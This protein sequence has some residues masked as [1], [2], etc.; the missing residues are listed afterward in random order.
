MSNK[1]IARRTAIKV[2]FGGVDISK[3]IDKYLLSLTYTDNEEDETD[4]LQIKLQDR[5]GIWLEKWLNKAI[6]GALE[7]NTNA[8]SSSGTTYTVT[9]KIGLPK[10]IEGM[11]S[12]CSAAL[13]TIRLANC[14][15]VV[16][17][18]SN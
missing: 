16:S 3:S 14:S 2:V 9:S 1:E 10:G 15:I 6:E 8:N 13:S 17:L 4:D 12:S 5:D 11:D 7:T 18:Q